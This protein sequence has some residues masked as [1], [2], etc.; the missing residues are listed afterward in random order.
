VGGVFQLSLRIFS[1]LSAVI[2]GEIFF[3]KFFPELSPYLEILILNQ[4][5]RFLAGWSLLPLSLVTLY[6]SGRW[7]IFSGIAGIFSA[8]LILETAKV[9]HPRNDANSI[10]NDTSFTLYSQNTLFDGVGN[11]EELIAIVKRLNP[12][13]IFFQEIDLKRFEEQ[14]TELEGWDYES[15]LSLEDITEGAF[16]F[17]IFSRFP[18]RNSRLLISEGP[19]WKPEWPLQICEIQIG[20]EWIA[21]ANVHLMPPHNPVTGPN[22]IPDQP[23]I[24]GKQIESVLASLPDAK[25]KIICGDFNLT[26]SAPQ[27]RRYFSHWIDSWKERGCGVGSTWHN[28]WTLFR[29]DYIYHTPQLKTLAIER[30]PNKFSDHWGMFAQMGIGN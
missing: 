28:P 3:L 29:I 27:H 23:E 2:S 30:V 13:V 5:L 16:S 8:F 17:A 18:I 12:E 14:I 1:L 7:R 24:I 26:P 20:G 15:F 19:F 10:T 4:T 22:L 11:E 21:C 25:A 9:P 6:V